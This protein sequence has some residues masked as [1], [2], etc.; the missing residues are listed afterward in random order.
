MLSKKELN[1][2]KQHLENAVNPV[3]FYDNDADGLCSYLLLRRFINRGNGAIVRSFPALGIDYFKRIEELSADYI[4][5]LDKPV[6][7]KEFFDEVEK[8]NIPV[9]WI[10]HHEIN[11]KDIPKFVHYYNPLFSKKKSNEPVT[12]ICYELTKRKEDLWLAVIGCVS[13]KFFPDFYSEFL[14]QFSDLSIDSKDAFK[15]Y[16]DSLIGKVARIFGCGLKDSARN[17]VFMQRFLEK[18]KSPH[19]ILEES[20]DTKFMHAR[21][22]FI[23]KRQEK[24]IS[25]A[26]SEAKDN[27]IFFKY[28]GDLSISS[29]LSNELIYRFPDK[30]ILVVYANG[31][32]ANISGRGKNIRKIVLDS[33][34]GLDGATGGG[35]EM[36]VGAQINISQLEEFEKRF[37]EFLNNKI[38]KH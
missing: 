37:M 8:I 31:Y 10:D 17:I 35:H 4:F 16:Y 6:V 19:F 9:V 13:D 33:I 20:E 21:F 32:K 25:K 28:A 3:F 5:I 22:N 23:N 11:K 15:I 14:K 36:A 29:D 34:N 12:A 27:F 30:L 18:V 38:Y 1:E 24:L 2:I 7:S 26:I